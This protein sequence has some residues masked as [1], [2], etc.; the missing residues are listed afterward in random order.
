M[1]RAQQSKATRAT[2][3]LA[4]A[5]VAFDVHTYVHDPA[6]ES[7]GQ[8]AAA[9]LG[10][11]PA[12]VFK[13]LVVRCAAPGPRGTDT[14]G[15]AV[16]PVTARLD[17]KAAAATFGAKRAQ[18][19]EAATAER[20]TGYVVGAISPLGQ[21]RRLPLTL[22]DSA[23]DLG[24]TLFVSGGRRGFEVELTPADLLAVTRGTTAPLAT[25]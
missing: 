5:R 9:A 4:A 18:L 12:R 7:F 8:E 22:D 3:A 21:Q 17:L 23:L 13:T 25:A 10:V 20:L 1:G 15:V 24:A 16:V 2:A 14:Y 11:D 6:A 19:A